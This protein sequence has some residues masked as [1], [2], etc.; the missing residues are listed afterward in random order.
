MT[1]PPPRRRRGPPRAPRSATA[2]PPISPDQCAR[3]VRQFRGGRPRPLGSTAMQAV[4]GTGRGAA[5][6]HHN[7]RA[8]LA[9]RDFRRLLQSRIASQLG[10]GLFQGG[11]AGSVFFNPQRAA[12]PMAIAAAFAVLLIPYS[13]L[14]PFVGVFLD[15]WS[16]QRVLFVANTARAALVLPAAWFV[17][18][19]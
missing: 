5:R 13:V 18:H 7:L 10:D 14:G 17:W 15:R 16:R 9:R 19:G 1:R 3:G 8:I 12:G 4:L 2:S 6:P 11:L